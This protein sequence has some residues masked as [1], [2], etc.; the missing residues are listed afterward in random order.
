MKDL[1]EVMKLDLHRQGVGSDFTDADIIFR[2]R[3]P[4]AGK[5]SAFHFVE[6]DL[7]SSDCPPGAEIR[8]T[9]HTSLPSVLRGQRMT[10]DA[11]A[12]WGYFDDS[13]PGETVGQI[14][15]RAVWKV[16]D[17][18]WFVSIPPPRLED[19]ELLCQI[20]NDETFLSLLPLYSF[21]RDR[22]PE[23]LWSS[24]E[25]RACMVVD[26]P[27]LHSVGYGF[28]NYENLVR[29][30]K[31][32]PFHAAMATVPLDFWYTSSRAARIF[33]DNPNALSLLIHGN[34]HL[35]YELAQ[36]STLK[37]CNAVA[38]TSLHRVRCMEA[39][40]DLMIDRVMA[41]LHGV[42]PPAMLDSLK[43]NGFNGVTT[44]R[45]SLW[46]DNPPESLPLQTGLYPADMLAGGLPV[47]NRF[48]F[49]ST[50]SD[51]E[52]MIASLLGQPLVPYGH[53]KDFVL[54]T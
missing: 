27:N 14:D 20:F 29:M 37:E 47:V 17:N 41:P 7:V 25:M 46:K 34:D 33:R 53:H 43:V 24:S 16:D 42:C 51:N 1:C 22:S 49:N 19:G 48:R 21:C 35:H 54:I 12:V 23:R 30:S 52:V 32:S 5:A 26:D 10:L 36:V 50:I 2:R 6:S 8:F 4:N 40:N 9:E 3:A 31:G 18:D 44:N 15:G 38:K 11:K 45:W 39:R 13:I 28:V